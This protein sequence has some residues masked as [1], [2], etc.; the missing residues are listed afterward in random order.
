MEKINHKKHTRAYNQRILHILQ[1]KSD[2][3]YTLKQIYA[4]L[5]V[6]THDKAQIK[7]NLTKL[8]QQQL[9]KKIYYLPFIMIW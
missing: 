6:K 9:I 4:K 1:Q 5:K 7:Q 2:T 3:G 8:C